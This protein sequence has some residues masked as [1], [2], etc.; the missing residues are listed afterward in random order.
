MQADVAIGA[1]SNRPD[2]PSLRL[3]VVLASASPRRRELLARAGLR[4]EVRPADVDETI[5]DHTTPEGAAE[6]LA[7]RKARAGAAAWR[8]AP[9]LVLG[10]DTIVAVGDDGPELEF[11]EKP[12]DAA[13]AARMLTRLS[14]TTHRVVTGVAVVRADGRGGIDGT[15]TLGHERTWVTMGTLAPADID[16]YVAGGEWEGKAGGYGI[17]GSADAFVTELSGGG[18]D[19]VVGLPVEL[20]R[21]LLGEADAGW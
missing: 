6:D 7:L 1:D 12:A 19:N 21:R 15:P 11:L 10:S 4:F 2:G 13:D 9:A 8:G 14:G 3:P 5:G 18:F 16:R 20:A 17:Q